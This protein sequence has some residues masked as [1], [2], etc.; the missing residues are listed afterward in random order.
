MAALA[1]AF[2]AADVSSLANRQ[3]TELAR[4]ISVAVG[5]AWNRNND[6]A[7]ADLSPVLDLAARTGVDLQ[8]RDTAGL[9]C[10]HRY[11]CRYPGRRPAPHP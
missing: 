11:R 9:R 2:A 5:T 4:A 10:I 8:I 3:R 7:S 1:A 6:W